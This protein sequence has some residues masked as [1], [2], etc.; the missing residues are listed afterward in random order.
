MVISLLQSRIIMDITNLLIIIIGDYFLLNQNY[1]L[2]LTMIVPWII[3]KVYTIDLGPLSNYFYSNNEKYCL[4]INDTTHEFLPEKLSAF[5]TDYFYENLNKDSSNNTNFIAYSSKKLKPVYDKRYKIQY[6]NTYIIIMVV[7]NS[8]LK[9][10]Y[11]KV[12]CSDLNILLD[13]IEYISNYEKKN[14]GK[15]D[16]KIIISINYVSNS[17]FFEINQLDYKPDNQYLP[18]LD[19][20][21]L[22]SLHKDI[23]NF[24]E[25]KQKY[26][27]IQKC[28]KRSYLF[29]GLPGTGKTNLIKYIA[30]RYKRNIYYLDVNSFTNGIE[31]TRRIRTLPNKSIIVLED[32]ACKEEKNDKDNNTEKTNKNISKKDFINILDGM[33]CPFDDDIIIMTT[34]NVKDIDPVLIR[35]GRIDYRIN[36]T[37]ATKEQICQILDSKKLEF[38]DKIINKYVG[39]ATIAEII[40]KIETNTFV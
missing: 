8:S 32:F 19:K 24:I 11:Y 13:F 14:I 28:Y 18:Y 35:P 2:L 12:W 38:S 7:L 16:N 20:N 1:R 27:D 34:N 29:E 5:L 9:E 33:L 3:N 4:N 15:N 40:N 36:F 39:K 6:K 31:C 21:I 23:D 25:S 17:L 37:Y 10:K 26:I 30:L 22:D